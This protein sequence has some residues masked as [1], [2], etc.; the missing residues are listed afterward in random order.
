MTIGT[1]QITPVFK[2]NKPSVTGK[3]TPRIDHPPGCR[4]P[5]PLPW[6]AT[7]MNT[8]A[9]GQSRGITQHYRALE[10][11]M[12]AWIAWFLVPA[13]HRIKTFG[14]EADRLPGRQRRNK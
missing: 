1:E 11:P 2:N 14:A 9:A 3:S 7:D 10:G 6:L 5:H 8:L 12:P 13:A 4:C